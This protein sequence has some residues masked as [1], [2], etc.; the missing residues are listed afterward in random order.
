MRLIINNRNKGIER[1]D[2]FFF[3][4][5]LILMVIETI[6]LYQLYPL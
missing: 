4:K 1:I 5:K 3:K 2:C 6:D